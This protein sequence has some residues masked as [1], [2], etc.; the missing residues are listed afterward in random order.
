MCCANR[1]CRLTYYPFIFGR[2]SSIIRPNTHVFSNEKGFCELQK[3]VLQMRKLAILAAVTLL[4]SISMFA[5]TITGS[6]TGTVAD[7]S[8]AVVT[9]VKIV[10]TNV[11][12]NVTH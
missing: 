9:N 8:G 3:G 6:I 4:G 5:Q 7:P 2:P 10:A 11:G 1:E 12:T